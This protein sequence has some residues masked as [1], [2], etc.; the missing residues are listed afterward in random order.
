M[1]SFLHETQKRKIRQRAILV[2]VHKKSERGREDLLDELASLCRTA[3]A[4]VVGRMVQG[5]ER[6][7]PATLIG[8]G[9]V[10]ELARLVQKEKADIIVFDTILAPSQQVNLEKRLSRQ[11]IETRLGAFIL[12]LEAT[13][14]AIRAG[15]A[16]SS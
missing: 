6:F 2:E 7:S 3:G 13:S 15:S 4:I 12:L 1:K 9:K 14:S 5:V 16:S 11:V 10:D 8:S